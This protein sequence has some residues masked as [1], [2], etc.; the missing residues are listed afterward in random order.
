MVH[1]PQTVMLCVFNHFL[2]FLCS[3]LHS[4]ILQLL[5][6]VY[7]SV[8]P[9]M[10]S[11]PFFEFSHW[12]FV[13]SLK[14]LKELEVMNYNRN[15]SYLMLN[16]WYFCVKKTFHLLCGSMN[17]LQLFYY[18]HSLDPLSLVMLIDVITS[19]ES[20]FHYYPNF[21]SQFPC[22]SSFLSRH[23]PENDSWPF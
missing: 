1:I 20:F 9:N 15:T 18:F 14:I 22:I 8:N 4:C 21:T 12:A 19:S 13:R 23:L 7:F 10:V 17:F 6:Y 5:F 16:I 11:A 3:C 2:L